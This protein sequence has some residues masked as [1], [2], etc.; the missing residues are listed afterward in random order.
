MSFSGENSEAAGTV[1]PA[2]LPETLPWRAELQRGE[3]EDALRIIEDRLAHDPDSLE[4][5][6]WWVRCQLEL[7][8]LPLSALTSPLQEIAEQLKLEPQLRQLSRKTYLFLGSRLL[9]RGQSR[10]AVLMLERAEEFADDGD[11]DTAAMREVYRQA[12]AAELERAK[13]RFEAPSYIRE[14]EQKLK[15]NPSIKQRSSVAPTDPESGET[16]AYSVNGKAK[17]RLLSSKTVLEHGSAAISEADGA[18]SELSFTSEEPPDPSAEAP[19]RAK[20]A[21]AIFVLL[22]LALAGGSWFLWGPDGDGLDARLAMRAE[23]VADDHLRLPP[24]P[25]GVPAESPGLDALRSRLDRLAGK[26]EPGARPEQEGAE[27]DLA[28]LEKAPPIPSPQPPATQNASAQGIEPLPPSRQEVQ[29]KT[30]LLDPER[31][32]KVQVEDGGGRHRGMP[33]D[34]RYARGPDGRLYGPGIGRPEGKALDGSRL[35]AYEVEEFQEP[36]LYKTLAATDVLEAPSSLAPAIDRIDANAKI[37]V[38]SR[39]GNWLELRSTGGRRGYIYAQDA[40]Q[41]K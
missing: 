22:L 35:Q 23:L 9:G 37:Q 27:V 12:L 39:M 2:A 26:L 32:A 24:L 41:A 36:V 20:L 13:S 17:S 19:K 5:R 30:P 38:V 4:T 18:S 21:P 7:G 31:L 8:A 14:V 16:P 10:L 1:D 15:D 34:G 29:A 11:A 33:I 6:L 25:V 3:F 28:Q 40:I